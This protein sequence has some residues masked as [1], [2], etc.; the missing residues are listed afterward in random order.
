MYIEKQDDQLQTTQ[1]TR[2]GAVTNP[3][4]IVSNHP[5]PSN[6]APIT[7]FWASQSCGPAG[8]LVPLLIKT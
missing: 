4:Q 8:W 5:A 7:V 2:G 3:V 6:G 1:L